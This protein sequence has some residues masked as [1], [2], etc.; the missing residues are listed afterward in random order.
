MS[1]STATMK[2]P[3]A[4]FR[5]KRNG[6]FC[7]NRWKCRHTPRPWQRLADMRARVPNLLLQMLL[8]ANNAVGYANYPD[9]VVKLFVRESAQAGID[10]FRIFDAL[11]WLP[12]MQLAIEAVR[13]ENKICEPAICY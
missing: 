9:N 8:R 12:N 5:S 2:P 4:I 7:A 1:L 10:V 11:N 13:A 3:C 6:A